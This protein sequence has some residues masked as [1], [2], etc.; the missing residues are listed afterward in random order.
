MI[1]LRNLII[2]NPWLP[3]KKSVLEVNSNNRYYKN[4]IN[5]KLSLYANQIQNVSDI[6][7]SQKKDITNLFDIEKSLIC[8]NLIEKWR[9]N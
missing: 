3:Q 4:F 2:S 7:L 6:F 5:S 1:K 8:M 9:S